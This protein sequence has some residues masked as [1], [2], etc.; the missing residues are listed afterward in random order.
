MG[1]ISKNIHDDRFS[2]ADRIEIYKKVM[3]N[4]IS[5]LASPEQY[6]RVPLEGM[7]DPVGEVYRDDKEEF[8]TKRKVF[9]SEDYETHSQFTENYMIQEGLDFSIN[10]S[11]YAIREAE[12][13][14]K[15]F[16]EK[17]NNLENKPKM[18]KLTR[19]EDEK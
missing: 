2:Q 15:R 6:A 9:V 19:K 16:E 11:N 13:A 14:A 4:P 7:P 10:D 8:L 12:N 17:Y 18:L 3:T 5:T 1:T